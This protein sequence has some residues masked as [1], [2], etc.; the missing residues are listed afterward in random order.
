MKKKK[1]RPLPGPF[2]LRESEE[3]DNKGKTRGS[4]AEK[5]R[6]PLFVGSER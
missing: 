5:G 2:H 6:G 3:R 4:K 1:N